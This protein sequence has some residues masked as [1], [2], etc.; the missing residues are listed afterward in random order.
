MFSGMHCCVGS[1]GGEENTTILGFLWKSVIQV[2]RHIHPGRSNVLPSR[3]YH[4]PIACHL[5]V[6]CFRNGSLWGFKRV[7]VAPVGLC[8][9]TDVYSE[10]ETHVV[11][12]FLGKA[13]AWSD[14][15]RIELRCCAIWACNVMV[16][17]F[18]I[19]LTKVILRFRTQY[20]CL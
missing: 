13:F 17:V 18:I 3:W 8:Y 12:L 20:I 2:T 9:S 16:A 10:Y 19:A 6:E 14:N 7:R 15:F 5:F 11:V 1:I 4:S